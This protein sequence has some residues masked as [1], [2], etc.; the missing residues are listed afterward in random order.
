MNRYWLRSTLFNLAFYGFTAMAC[1]IA[2]PSY[3]IPRTAFLW[4][5]RIYLAIN[6]ALERFILGLSY[7]VR[8]IENLPKN[9]CFIVAA[10][11]QSAYE[12]LKLHVLFE[13]PAVILKKELLS[14]PI[15][16]G[17]LKKSDV[18]A[19]DRSSKEQAM[20]SI[21]EGAKR[22]QEQGRP[23]IIFPQGTR[24]DITESAKE[25]PYK[26]GVARLYEATGLPVI[27]LALNTGYYYPRRGWC[28]RPGRVVF[29]FL[30]ALE[31][32]L[33]REEFMKRLETG[34]EEKSI[35][36]L[37][38][39]RYAEKEGGFPF[40]SVIFSL[41]LLGV[42]LGG[43]SWLWFKTAEIIKAQHGHGQIAGAQRLVISPL[44]I[45]GFPGPLRISGGEE[46]IQNFEGSIHIES[47]TGKGYPVPFL[48]VRLET[49]KVEI[50]SF[51]YE[52]PLNIDSV[53]LTL[54][55]TGQNS[56][57]I[58]DS[59]IKIGE[60]TAAPEG[61][62]TLTP[63]GEPGVDLIVSLTNHE[64]LL[65]L[66][67]QKHMLEERSALFIGAGLSAFSKDGIVKVPITIRE[68]VIYAG[69]FAVATLPPKIN[70][71]LS[72]AAP[73]RDTLPAPS[74]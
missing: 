42:L 54:R 52:E 48:P 26:F 44:Q 70:P 49:G 47:F 7:E 40:K 19:I 50:K 45:S 6:T 29:E 36:L 1:F 12:T 55:I 24:V 10:K 5:V 58:E 62:I 23:I 20:N 28:R 39:A 63:E 13:D 17:F 71:A 11:H 69:P 31:P 68:R 35:E 46:F 60:F 41:L 32:S 4:V 16:G 30:P 65:R 73:A 51:R 59:L 43:Y 14:I 74:P 72:S 22:M 34:L 3:F 53:A 8:G 15:W 18:I 27:P 38:D 56:A 67:S 64:A 37:Q 33:K 66:L 2:L 21:I 9:G 25:K 57:R 61:N